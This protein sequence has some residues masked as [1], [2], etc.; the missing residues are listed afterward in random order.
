[1]ARQFRQH[2]GRTYND[3]RNSR[4]NFI[5]RDNHVTG[6]RTV[7]HRKARRTVKRQ[8]RNGD[9]ARAGKMRRYTDHYG[10]YEY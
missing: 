4:F 6:L 8:I 7:D 3:R 5:S 9:E 2:N 1:M 10:D